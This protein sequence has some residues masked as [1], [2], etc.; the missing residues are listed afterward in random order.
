MFSSHGT[1]SFVSTTCLVSVDQRTK[2]GCRVV[3]AICSGTF[4]R[5]PISTPHCQSRAVDSRQEFIL[6]GEGGAFAGF[7][8]V[9]WPRLRFE[10]AR[11]DCSVHCI[12]YRPK[13]QIVSPTV[14]PITSCPKTDI[15]NVS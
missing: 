13:Y 11:M 9:N 6:H 5:S 14:P 7:Y 4:N 8:E 3:I 15:H 1:V 10:V 2:S 12:G